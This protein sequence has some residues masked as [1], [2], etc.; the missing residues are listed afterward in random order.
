MLDILYTLNLASQGEIKAFY[1]DLKATEEMLSY[2][3]ENLARTLK[4]GFGDNIRNY[5]DNYQVI[6]LKANIPGLYKQCKEAYFLISYFNKVLEN[7]GIK[8]SFELDGF[9]GPM[10]QYGHHAD[11]K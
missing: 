9:D 1:G 5:I 2:E 6:S 3:R 8:K 7:I 11:N 10:L 4:N